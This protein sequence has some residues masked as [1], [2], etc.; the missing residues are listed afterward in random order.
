MMMA[1]IRVVA[2]V[3]CLL[4]ITL[5]FSLFILANRLPNEISLN[6]EATRPVSDVTGRRGLR[7]QFKEYNMPPTDSVQRSML[8]PL[9]SPHLGIY[10][11]FIKIYY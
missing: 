9:V 3:A 2:T 7:F 4:S 8:C 1:M 11:Q 6:A 5:T 10:V